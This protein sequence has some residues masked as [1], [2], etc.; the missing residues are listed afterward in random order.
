MISAFSQS[1]VHLSLTVLF[2][3]KKGLGMSAADYTLNRGLYDFE[4]TIIIQSVQLCIVQ[5]EFACSTYDTCS[6]TLQLKQFQHVCES[7]I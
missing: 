3:M 7:V 1:I 4:G 6:S 5:G 2:S